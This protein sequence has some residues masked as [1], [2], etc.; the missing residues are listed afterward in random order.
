MSTIK[1]SIS[2]MMEYFLFI[3]AVAAK[4]SD[5]KEFFDKHFRL[6]ALNKFR[7]SVLRDFITRYK[8]FIDS[9]EN[10]KLTTLLIVPDQKTTEPEAEKPAGIL[11]KI[12]RQFGLRDHT[13][14]EKILNQLNEETAKK[15]SGR[16]LPLK[17]LK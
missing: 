3:L 14:L 6:S 8:L 5:H 10:E 12:L 11:K 16:E 7:Q 4:E 15:Y 13:E 17:Y 1:L 9:I 2:E